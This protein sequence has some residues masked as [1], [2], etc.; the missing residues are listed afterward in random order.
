MSPSDIEVV[1]PRGGYP[2]T[3]TVILLHD[4][5]SDCIEFSVKFFKSEA[6]ESVDEPRTLADIFP[7]IRWVFPSALIL[8]SS[9]LN[10]PESQWFDIWSMERPNERPE[11]QTNGLQN[12]IERLLNF[13]EEEELRVPPQ[14]IFIGGI[15][16]GFAT[17]YSAYLFSA[18][19]YGGLIDIS[20][21]A[22]LEALAMLGG[23]LDDEEGDEPTPV[24]VAHCRDDPIVPV[25]EGRALSS[26]LWLRP[27][28][29]VD[30]H[31]YGSGGHWINEPTGVD[32]LVDFLRNN[33]D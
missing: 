26:M 15:S 12:S 1:G 6:S 31:E 8:H 5:G 4:K 28:T 30:F 16:Q 19:G 9:R 32:D 2:H 22:P 14:S 27:E 24:F 10:C 18:R 17:A 23:E 33:M 29:I 21:W 7:T 25:N 3:H 13:I 11:L 20:G